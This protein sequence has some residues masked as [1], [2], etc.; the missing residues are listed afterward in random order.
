MN[1]SQPARLVVLIS[2]TGRNLQ[3]L[4]DAAERDDLHARIVLVISNRPGVQGLARAE[5]AGIA[6]QTIDHRDYPTREAFDQVLG[7]AIAAVE[8]DIVAL[9]GFMR[10]LTAEFIRRFE[11]R[12]LNIHP[13]L[14]PKYRGLQT[15]RRA[16]EA[17]DHWHGASIHF[18]TEEL[19]GGPVV[20]QGRIAVEP[21]DT[22]E[23]LARRVMENVELQ[24][25]PAAVRWMADGRLR[26]RDHVAWLDDTQLQTPALW[27]LEESTE[28]SPTP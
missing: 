13:S 10:I 14:L 21:T 17:A 1:P 20:L 12:M 24:I 27:P 25:Y 28:D 7:D 4:I 23:T 15:H 19:D 22:E 2:G 3:A 5:A 26:L 8:P 6:T 16:L 11:G 18:V 9:A